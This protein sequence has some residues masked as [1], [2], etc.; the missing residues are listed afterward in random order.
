ML[1]SIRSRTRSVNSF[2]FAGDF[3]MVPS[4]N[5]FCRG[6]EAF[7]SAVQIVNLLCYLLRSRQS[8]AGQP[9]FPPLQHVSQSRSQANLGLPGAAN[10]KLDVVPEGARLIARPNQ[11][12][13]LGDFE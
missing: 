12:G 11:F 13:P 10:P 6:S 1:S 4:L 9:S 8:R 7:A 3:I 5:A 2:G